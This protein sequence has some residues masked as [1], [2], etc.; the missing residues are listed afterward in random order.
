MIRI[1]QGHDIII[2]DAWAQ[3][4]EDLEAKGSKSLEA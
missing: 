4:G 2:Y 3:Q 1:K